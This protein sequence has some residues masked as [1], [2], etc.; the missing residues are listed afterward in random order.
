MRRLSTIALTS[1]AAI[2]LAACSTKE[3]VQDERESRYQIPEYPKLDE[4]TT[5]WRMD[6]LL[7]TGDYMTRIP[8]YGD[9]VERMRSL[10]LYAHTSVMNYNWTHCFFER[11]DGTQKK[12]ILYKM[13]SLNARP[14]VFFNPNEL[15]DGRMVTLLRYRFSGDGAC[16]ALIVRYDSEHAN[17]EEA[18]MFFDV[19]TGIEYTKDRLTGLRDV[20]PCWGTD[21]LFYGVYEEEGEMAYGQPLQSQRVMFHKFGTTQQDD[22]IALTAYNKLPGYCDIRTYGTDMTRVFILHVP[23][24]ISHST[25]SLINWTR[26]SA[27]IICNEPNS[28]CFPV[29][30]YYDTIYL[31]SNVLDSNGGLYGATV[32]APK[33]ADWWP[34]VPPTDK[35]LKDAGAGYHNLFLT[36]YD[37]GTTQAQIF[38]IHGKKI[39]EL[40]MPN[41]GT[42]HFYGAFES[43]DI[44]Y[45]VS[46]FAFPPTIYK[47]D[48]QTN[49]SVPFSHSAVDFDPELYTT[50]LKMIFDP[51]DPTREVPVYVTYSKD[52]ELDGTAPCIV[53]ICNDADMELSIDFDMH[54]IIMLENGCVYAQ[55][56]VHNV[57][58]DISTVAHYLCEEGYTS[59]QYMGIIAREQCADFIAR[60]MLLDSN[61]KP[62]VIVLINPTEEILQYAPGEAQIGMEYPSTFIVSNLDEVWQYAHAIQHYTKHD[63]NP[64]LI[65]RYKSNKSSG[66][67]LEE[68]ATTFNF[69]WYNI[70]RTKFGKNDKGSSILEKYFKSK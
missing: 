13:R 9:I 17:G 45:S 58:Q 51:N 46:S 66:L 30:R 33:V 63:K 67:S 37:K 11:N 31:W 52:I 18:V 6:Q 68:Y 64:K 49:T 15:Y 44:F 53:R 32:E 7:L 26:H 12:D 5:Q 24:D 47:Y 23:E 28:F 22:E 27:N 62:A 8:F 14:E 43:R 50:E 21:G 39:R 1:L 42:A 65:F 20:Y 61:R 48:I 57:E 41:F 60:D 38:D 54:N 16:I 25:L 70:G 35:M 40:S 3:P 2:L 36:Y 56:M 29:A 10:Q 4:D 55:A 19:E 34:V 59:P 69:Y